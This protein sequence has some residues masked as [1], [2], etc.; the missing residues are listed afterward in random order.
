VKQEGELRGG[1]G[2]ILAI[3]INAQNSRVQQAAQPCLPMLRAGAQH[4]SAVHTFFQFIQIS[5]R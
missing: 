3:E 5:K 1:H 4:L 2:G